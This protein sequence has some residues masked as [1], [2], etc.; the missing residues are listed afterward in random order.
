[1]FN[2]KYAYI[3]NNENGALFIFI[4]KIFLLYFIEG[5]T[6]TCCS[7]YSCI[8]WLLL[9]CALTRARTCNLG[10]PG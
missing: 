2:V 8:H 3:M 7:T 9:V 10:V 6:L 4:K 1:M 5:D